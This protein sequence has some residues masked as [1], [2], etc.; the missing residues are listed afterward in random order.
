MSKSRDFDPEE[1]P[2]FPPSDSDAPSDDES[3]DE[4]EGGREHYVDVGKSKLRKKPEGVPL[5]PQYKGS[6]VSRDIALDEDSDDPFS[7]E[8]GWESSEDE[9][10]KEE[11]EGGIAVPTNGVTHHS[12]GSDGSENADEEGEFSDEDEDEG[13]EQEKVRF[14]GDDFEGF[15]SE[16]DDEDDADGSDEQDDAISRA[17]LRKIMS[18][19]QKSITATVSQAAKTDAEKGEAVKAQRKTFDSILNTRIRLQKALISSNS[20][21]S[22][23]DTEDLNKGED[24]VQAAENAAL[25]LLNT[26][27]GL[28]SSLNAAQAGTKRKRADSF[29]LETSSFEIWKSI[30][31]SESSN[32]Q[33]RRT[34]LEKWSAKSRPAPIVPQTRRLNSSAVSE[35]TITDVLNT[36]MSDSARLVKRTRIPRSCAPVQVAAGVAESAEIYDDADFYGL[37]LKEL[38]EQRSE[39]VSMQI[40]GTGYVAQ[41]PWQAVRDAKT[42]RIVDTKASKGRKL[43]YTVHEKLQNYMAPEDRNTWGERQTDEL[44]GSLFGRKTELAEDAEQKDEE[45]SDD[46]DAA[47]QG[48]LLFRS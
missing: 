10:E 39:D 14:G 17:E 43:R 46:E 42:K 44:F 25:A 13:P 21:P 31:A 48:L 30:K 23:I 38:L 45:M 12:S 32:M 22:A 5:G 26:L 15:E 20:L 18:E 2:N 16:D 4:E 27:S 41:A 36:H 29:I 47:E 37:L 24:A 19:E 34:V 7:K 11:G 28:R 1:I 6:K 33:N 3:L 40:N 9:E 35:Q 8:V